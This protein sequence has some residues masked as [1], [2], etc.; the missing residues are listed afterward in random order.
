[1]GIF[2][3]INDLENTTARLTTAVSRDDQSQQADRVDLLA[4]AKRTVAALE[5]PRG[6]MLEIAK[7]VRRTSSISDLM[8]SA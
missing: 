4:A 3:L 5:D 1:M 8:G 6:R 2:N 7:A